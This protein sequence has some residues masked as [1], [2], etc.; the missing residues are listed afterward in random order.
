MIGDE[1][2]RSP[3]HLKLHMPPSGTRYDTPPQIVDFRCEQESQCSTIDTVLVR[4]VCFSAFPRT[5]QAR[6]LTDKV[7]A[8]GLGDMRIV[9]HDEP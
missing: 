3:D 9:T 7:L 5:S 8:H 2:R 1:R 6:R 4:F